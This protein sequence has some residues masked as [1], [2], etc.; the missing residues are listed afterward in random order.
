VFSIGVRSNIGIAKNTSLEVERGI[1]VNKNMKTSVDNIFACGDVAQIENSVLAIWPTAIEMGRIA[2]ANACGDEIEFENECYPVSLDAM[3]AKVFTLG[4]I[5]DYDGELCLKD[6]KNKIY[7]KLFIK[8]DKL[9][10]AILI[11]DMSSTVKVMR[12]MAQDASTSE[13]ANEHII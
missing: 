1:V 5:Q 10:G 3:E 6:P 9:V 4:N 8:D 2:G 12:L 13:V 11:N 7:K